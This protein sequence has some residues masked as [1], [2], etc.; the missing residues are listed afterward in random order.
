MA[1]Q[2]WAR[3]GRT[4]HGRKFRQGMAMKGK[5]RQFRAWH[6][7]QAGHGRSALGTAV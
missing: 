3:E 2:I 6:G 1:R 4:G 5:A 7:R